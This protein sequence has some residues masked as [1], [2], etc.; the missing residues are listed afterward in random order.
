VIVG[1]HATPSNIVRDVLLLL[2]LQQTRGEFP[3]LIF[4]VSAH[5]HT[6]CR[7]GTRYDPVDTCLPAGQ[8]ASKSS[9]PM[10]TGLNSSASSL[11]QFVIIEATV[12][13]CRLH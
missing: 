3:N 6:A 10:P 13:A 1:Y 12:R 11:Q 2:L 5:D 4:K 8:G 9:Q 7:E